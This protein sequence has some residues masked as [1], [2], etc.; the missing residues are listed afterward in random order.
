[1]PYNGSGVFSVVNTF[2]PNTTISSSAMN[3]N[4]SDIATNGLSNVLVRDGQAAMTGQFKAANG[5]VNAPSI[6]FGT[7]LDTGFYR[8]GANNFG[9][10]IGGEKL[11]D[12]S[13]QLVGI[14]GALTVSDIVRIANGT[15][16]APSLTFA[17]D[18]DTG[19]YRI[20][21]N[22]IGISTNGS[23][24]FDIG[25]T[26]VTV[27]GGLSVT[28]A[29]SPSSLSGTI[30]GNPTFSGN[31]TFSG[32]PVFSGNIS[33]SGTPT[34]SG[35]ATASGAWTYSSTSGVT[36]RNTVKA[37]GYVEGFSN[38]TLD[39]SFNI[40][41]F[42]RPSE[43]QYVFSFTNN[44]SNANYCVVASCGDERMCFIESGQTASGFSVRVRDIN[45]GLS[46]N[47][48]RMNVI[49]MGI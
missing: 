35:A 17:G 1:M 9:V 45:N 47:T 12:F 20:G 7:D 42:S 38:P 31:A 10:S 40:G 13:G 4:F 34:I 3:A 32:T 27:N 48:A 21:S 46:A 28:G 2:V 33:L 49:V 43:G 26:S 23:N 11:V 41:S 29:F 37:W 18:P 24:I 30:S 19:L 25:N 8:I 14:T 44:M 15:A 22:R 16:A 6:T 39:A 5:T 36:A